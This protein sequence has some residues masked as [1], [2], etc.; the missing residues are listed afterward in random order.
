MIRSTWAGISV[1]V[2][3]CALF[4]W[5]RVGTLEWR[6]KWIVVIVVLLSMLDGLT[7]DFALKAWRWVN[8][9]Q[10][11]LILAYKLV[12]SKHLVFWLLPF[13]LSNTTTTPFWPH[14][15]DCSPFLWELLA[16]SSIHMSTTG[17]SM[18]TQD[19]SSPWTLLLSLGVDFLFKLDKGPAPKDLESGPGN[20]NSAWLCYWVEKM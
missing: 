11:E 16:A 17:A 15:G 4:A 2:H 8:S 13:C 7:E 14:F 1:A 10:K 3:C 9:K 6:N 18:L 5:H 12:C 19:D 20:P